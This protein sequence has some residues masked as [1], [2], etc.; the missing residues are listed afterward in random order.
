MFKVLI[1]YP[2]A[3][4]E[5][6]MLMNWQGGRYKRKSPPVTPVASAEEI[7][8]CRLQLDNIKVDESIV[9]YLVDLISRSRTIS[10]LHL[11]ASPRAA[12]SWLAASKA[13]AAIEGKDFRHSR[14]YQVCG[15]T[16]FE[17]SPDSTAEAELTVS[18]SHR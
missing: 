13:H 3:E 16:G 18:L 17:T 9:G 5:R 4:A 10:D 6:Q 14:Q 1:S 7:V 2:N 11:G 8:E 12:L 15:R